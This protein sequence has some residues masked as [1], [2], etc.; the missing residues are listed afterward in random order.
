MTSDNFMSRVPS[1]RVKSVG[2]IPEVKSKGV[3]A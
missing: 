3:L 1:S 2:H